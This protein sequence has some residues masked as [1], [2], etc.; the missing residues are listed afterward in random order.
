MKYMILND[1]KK[2]KQL[3]FKISFYIWSL[4]DFD[5]NLSNISSLCSMR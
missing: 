5:K 2:N 1:N 4:K 3:D